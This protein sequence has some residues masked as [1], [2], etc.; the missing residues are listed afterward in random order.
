MQISLWFI[1]CSS[2]IISTC[3]KMCTVFV[4]I[5]LA[6]LVLFQP[7]F[8]T[9]LSWFEMVANFETFILWWADKQ[10]VLCVIPRKLYQLI[11][12]FFFLN[13]WGAISFLDT[14]CCHGSAP[15]N[16]HTTIEFNPSAPIVKKK[17]SYSGRNIFW[18]YFF[19][20]WE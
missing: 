20:F 15:A 12:H 3:Q 11:C 7:I 18:V 16:H 2:I 4:P 13:R 8:S 1:T 10:T 9:K 6:W 17:H 14:L 5:I 19:L